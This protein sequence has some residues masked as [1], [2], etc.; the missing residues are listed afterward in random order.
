PN[1]AVFSVN[2]DGMLIWLSDRSDAAESFAK[3]FLLGYNGNGTG[4]DGKATATDINGNPKPYTQAGNATIYA[5]VDAANFIGVSFDDARVPDLIGIAQYGTV[6]TGGKGK[7]AEHGGNNIQDKHAP[8]LV[9]G[10]S[11]AAGGTSSS[12]VEATQI[13]PTILELLGINPN[14][15]Q[16]VR[17][18]HTQTLALPSADD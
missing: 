14:S 9:S 1:L 17:A 2:D 4:S 8:I 18:E 16:A 11:V 5:G 12:I 13:A 7:I 3:N 10:G 15:L 6:Y